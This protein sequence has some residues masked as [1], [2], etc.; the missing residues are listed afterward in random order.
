MGAN[1]LPQCLGIY[2]NGHVLIQF[3]ANQEQGMYLGVDNVALTMKLDV[4]AK[5]ARQ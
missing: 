3:S 5:V 4:A 1:V 2:P